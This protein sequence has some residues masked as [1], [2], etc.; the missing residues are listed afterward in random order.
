MKHA[1]QTIRAPPPVIYAHLK[2]MWARGDH[3]KSLTWLRTFTSRLADDL[4][5]NL[6]DASDRVPEVGTLPKM[7]EYTNLLAR[8]YLKQ[9]EWQYSMKQCWTPVGYVFH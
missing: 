2:F 8:C 5:L 1:L 4:D 3:E 9:G 7:N 6:G